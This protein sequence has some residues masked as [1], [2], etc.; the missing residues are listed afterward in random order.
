VPI[1]PKNEAIKAALKEGIRE[2]LDDQ[3]KE[4]GKWTFRGLTAG[5]LA[6]AVWL[7][8]VSNGWVHKP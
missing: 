7:M 2:W 8:L 6:G 3:F 1:D 4:L 5:I